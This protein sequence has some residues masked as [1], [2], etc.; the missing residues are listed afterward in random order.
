M[1]CVIQRVRSAS[2][3]VNDEI[4][5]R[6]GEGLLVLAA[7]ER[8]D[9]EADADWTAHKLLT[10]RI[11]P[12][13]DKRFD[14]D[15]LAANAQVLLVSNFTVAADAA[16]GRRPSLSNAADPETGRRLFDRLVAACRS[17]VGRCETGR[18]GADMLVDS[19]NDGPVT[20]VL[21]SNSGKAQTP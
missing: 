12:N 5:G 3:R 1:I 2:V 13:G 7:V 9:T 8:T 15:V 16:S 20:F 14:L 17:G 10:L 4:V 11:F 19:V 6:I 18:F 21:D